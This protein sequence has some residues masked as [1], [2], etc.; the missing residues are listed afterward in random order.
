MEFAGPRLLVVDFAACFRFYRDVIGLD[1]TWGDE[2]SSYASFAHQGSRQKVLALFGRQ[3][4]AEAIGTDQ[5]PLAAA[6]QDRVMYIFEVGDVDG[7]WARLQ[8]QGSDLVA[9]PRDHPEWGIRS[10]YVRD[11][12]GNLLEL[13]GELTFEA[14]TE[15]LQAEAQKYNTE[16]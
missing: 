14:W 16:G 7:A 6:A 8:A 1:P 13:T 5:L 10:A 11:P 3:E 9:E 2:E 12:D 15:E 4:M